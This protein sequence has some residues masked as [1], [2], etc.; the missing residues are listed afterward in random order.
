[1]LP[2]KNPIYWIQIV[3]NALDKTYYEHGF[4]TGSRWC[5]IHD[6]YTARY[7]NPNSPYKEYLKFGASRCS[8]SA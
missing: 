1:M 3:E 7:L 6:Y 8:Q 4:E 5:K 2:H